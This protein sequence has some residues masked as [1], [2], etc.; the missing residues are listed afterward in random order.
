MHFFKYPNYTHYQ[1]AKLHN[2]VAST[3]SKIIH[4]INIIYYII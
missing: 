1:I 3:L 4:Y 2:N